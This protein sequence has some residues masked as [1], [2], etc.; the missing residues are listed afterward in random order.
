MAKGRERTFTGVHMDIF[1]PM[2]ADGKYQMPIVLPSNHIPKKLIA[3]NSVK[4]TKDTECG[5]HFFIDDYQ[6][7][8][9]WRTP[10]LYINRLKQFDC[11]LTPYF[12][13]YTDMSIATQIWNVYRSRLLG[14]F[15]QA[16]NIKVIP[17]LQWSTKES[18]D[19]CF[20][21]LKQGGTVA[22]STIGVKRYAEAT[23]RWQD[24][25]TEAINRLKPDHII[26]YGEPVEYDF[27]D[28][29]IINISNTVT[30]WRTNK[31]GR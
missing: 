29:D 13:L 20:D 15:M 4:T 16:H 7:E 28:T 25:M 21:G 2:L 19:F 3:F 11:V 31:D 18:F 26:L 24:G 10:E 27:G 5:V 6:F 30:S 22:V 8:R 17:T 9:L 14:Q 23:Q 12:S 1:N